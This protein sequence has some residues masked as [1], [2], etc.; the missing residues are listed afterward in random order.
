MLK[1]NKTS[2]Q[3]HLER[4]KHVS[5]HRLGEAKYSPVFEMDEDDELDMKQVQPVT[6]NNTGI[7]G[8]ADDD[9]ITVND[10]DDPTGAEGAIGDGGPEGG[11]EPPVEQPA[12]GEEVADVPD[13]N[14]EADPMTMEPAQPS[15]TEQREDIQ[16]Q[17]IKLQLSALEQ[18]NDK[19][20]MMDV[21]MAELKGVMGK[22]S[23]EVEEVREPTNVEKVAAR[24][25]D[26]HP[27]Y[28]RLNDLWQG[29]SFQARLDDGKTGEYGM[30]Q[31]EDGTYV[32]DFDNFPKLNDL[33][34]KRS[35]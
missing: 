12:A 9:E 17:L 1:K 26:S 25:Q 21:T 28:Y 15:A 34:L 33:D 11:A 7:F 13:A 19:M 29:N 27:Y 18:M 16:N 30:K 20:K 35:F 6:A 23:A 5:K 14:V 32:A 10:L 22:L 31:L 4:I 8:E 3:E 2:L 24:K